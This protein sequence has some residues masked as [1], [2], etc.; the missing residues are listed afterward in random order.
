MVREALL[1]I[2]SAELVL[3]PDASPNGGMQVQNFLNGLWM[4]RVRLN[5]W[6]EV[7]RRLPY[8]DSIDPGTHN[9]P[10]SAEVL[11]GLTSSDR[12]ALKKRICELVE[13]LKER[14]PGFVARFPEQFS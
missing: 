9:T 5:D 1:L 8:G 10:G 11:A 14:H 2:D 6:E 13:D 7:A 3:D 4:G 12:E